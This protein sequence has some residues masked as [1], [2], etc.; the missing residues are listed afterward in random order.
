MVEFIE[1]RGDNRPP[2]RSFAANDQAF[3][4]PKRISPFSVE[5]GR[6]KCTFCKMD[7][8][9]PANQLRIPLYVFLPGCKGCKGRRR[10]FSCGQLLQSTKERIP[11]FVAALA[12]FQQVRPV[13]PH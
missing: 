4:P 9:A 12:T 7:V 1:N 13:G 6:D 10:Y 8:R 2:V 5:F 3:S 11:G